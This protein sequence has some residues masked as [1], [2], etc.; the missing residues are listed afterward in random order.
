MIGLMSK[1]GRVL[2]KKEVRHTPDLFLI[3]GAMG[4]KWAKQFDLR[5]NFNY[6]HCSTEL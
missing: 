1:S 6:N 3:L 4:L 5:F 2:E